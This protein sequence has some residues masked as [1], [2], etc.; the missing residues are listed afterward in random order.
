M[1]RR[2]SEC[3]ARAA[4]CWDDPLRARPGPLHRAELSSLHRIPGL[5]IDPSL[6]KHAAAPYAP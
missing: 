3:Y 1:P 2:S 5:V 4:V 6:T